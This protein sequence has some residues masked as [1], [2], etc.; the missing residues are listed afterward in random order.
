VLLRVQP[1]LRA[2]DQTPTLIV[3]RQNRAA[4]LETLRCAFRWMASII[5]DFRRALSE[6]S[7]SIIRAKLPVSP[8]RFNRLH[9][10]F[11]GPYDGMHHTNATRC[12]LSLKLRPSRTKVAAVVVTLNR[13]DVDRLAGDPKAIGKTER[14]PDI[15]DVIFH[16]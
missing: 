15:V 3:G 14:R 7:P 11:G 10:V 13:A 16:R 5:T 4:R 1:A 9:R 8:H 6:V 2:P 12:D